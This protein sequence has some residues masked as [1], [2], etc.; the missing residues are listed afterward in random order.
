MLRHPVPACYSN[1]RTQYYFRLE[2]QLRVLNEIH[3][4]FGMNEKLLVLFA[5]YPLIYNGA[6][7]NWGSK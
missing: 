1:E 4:D 5:L 2:K 6:F 7:Y 3:C